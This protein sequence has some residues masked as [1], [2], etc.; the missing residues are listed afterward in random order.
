MEF[1]S[2]FVGT[3]YLKDLSICDDLIDKFK[4]AKYNKG[5]GL[6]GGHVNHEWKKSIDFSPNFEEIDEYLMALK[7]DALDKYVEKYPHSAGDAFDITALPNIQYYPPG[8]GFYKWH[9]EQ[10]PMDAVCMS[11]NLVFMTYLNDVNDGGETEFDY[12]NIKIKPRKGLTVIWPAGWPFTHRG[13][14]S[15]TEKKYIITGW[16]NYLF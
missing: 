1:P 12:Q 6:S 8:G 5:P 16:Y 9:Y 14:V 2:E 15:K 7:H 10:S 11:R 3:A 13:V 4:N